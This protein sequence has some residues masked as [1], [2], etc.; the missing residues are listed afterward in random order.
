[1]IERVRAELAKVSAPWTGDRALASD[2]ER[3]GEWIGSRAMA[4][5]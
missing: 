5:I 2:I 3:V 4:G 1:V